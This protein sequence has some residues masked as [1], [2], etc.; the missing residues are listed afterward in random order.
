[1]KRDQKKGGGERPWFNR[2]K[3]SLCVYASV[4]DGFGGRRRFL[5]LEWRSEAQ[6]KWK[7]I[8]SSNGEDGRTSWNNNYTKKRR[9]PTP[10]PIGFYSF[11]LSIHW[12]CVRTYRSIDDAKKKEIF[13]DIAHS[14]YLKK[15][16]LKKGHKKKKK[17][18]LI[19]KVTPRHN[20]R[21]QQK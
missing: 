1:M 13:P 3:E 12:K 16:P 5:D 21:K 11:V 18:F 4:T 9:D 20:E 8:R 19:I 6:M 2:I 17:N 10:I 14:S 7:R 15:N